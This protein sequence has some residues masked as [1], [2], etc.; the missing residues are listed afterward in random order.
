[1]MR[2]RTFAPLYIALAFLVS[3]PALA[4]SNGNGGGQGNGSNRRALHIEISEDLSFGL[5]AQTNGSGGAI[6]IDPRTGQ[7]TVSGGLVS[8]AGNSFRGT[9]LLTGEPFAQVR[10]SLPS[11]TRM[12]APQGASAEIVDLH[13]EVPPVITLDANGRFSFGFAGRFAITSG[14]SGEFRGRFAISADY[15]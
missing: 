1:M 14:D 11:S 2:R 13:A 6:S 15:E 9:V 5:A 3:C 4:Q 10:I 12:H 7:R 8:V